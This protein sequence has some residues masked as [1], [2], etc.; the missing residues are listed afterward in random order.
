MRRHYYLFILLCSLTFITGCGSRNLQIEPDEIPTYPNASH[1]ARSGPTPI[2]FGES[3]TWEFET[4]DTPDAVW[5]YFKLEMQQ[6]W[7]F[8]ESQPQ[9]PGKLLI[10]QSCPFYYLEMNSEPVASS[11]YHVTIS[12]S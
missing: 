4:A 3:Y 8:Y 10:V 2:G 12:F 9:N 6:R 5:N 7:D 11:L 1:I